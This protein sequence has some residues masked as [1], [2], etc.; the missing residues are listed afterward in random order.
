MSIFKNRNWTGPLPLLPQPFAGFGNFCPSKLT[1]S[2]G[3]WWYI[4]KEGN[5][6]KSAPGFRWILQPYDAKVSF[7]VKFRRKG[8]YL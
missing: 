2:P 5:R 7:Y 6:R 4:G 1:T 3:R 8:T